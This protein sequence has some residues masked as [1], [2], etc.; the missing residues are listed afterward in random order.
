MSDRIHS[1]PNQMPAGLR[2]GDL[3]LP[4]PHVVANDLRGREP[5][6]RREERLRVEALEGIAHENPPER[7]DGQAV[8][9][10]ERG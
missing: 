9:T 5:Q 7:H 3:H 2:E 10:D 6:I 4:S 1:R 8:L